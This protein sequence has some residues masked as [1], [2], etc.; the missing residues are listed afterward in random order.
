MTTQ[1]PHQS[2]APRSV[3]LP[4]AQSDGPGILLDLALEASAATGAALLVPEGAMLAVLQSRGAN[5]PA[6]PLPHAAITLRPCLSL[7]PLVSS[8]K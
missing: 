2:A 6:V 1:S 3:A 5:A 8:S 7:R 4:P